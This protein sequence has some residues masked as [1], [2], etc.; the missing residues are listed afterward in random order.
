MSQ[1]STSRSVVVELL[2][3]GM[4]DNHTLSPDERYLAL[5]GANPKN[6]FVVSLTQQ[7]FTEYVSQL[8]YVGTNP[9]ATR[10]ARE[11]LE[12]VVRGILS[13]IPGLQTE[14][15]DADWLHLRLVVTPRELGL[16]PFELALTPD[17]FPGAGDRPFL[18]NPQRLTTLTRE[19]RQAT[20]R[21]YQWPTVPRI[22]FV[23]ADPGR[24]VPHDQHLDS[25]MKAVRGWARPLGNTAEPVPDMSPLIKEVAHATL[26]DIRQEFK[27]ARYTHVHILA[28]GTDVA[29]ADGGRRFALALH[30]PGSRAETDAVDGA[31][32]ADALVSVEGGEARRPAVVV[33][34]A[35]DSG[36]EGT[37]IFPG[38]SLAHAL[39]SYSIPYVLAS[40]FPLTEEGSVA[41]VDDLYPRLFSGEDPR[42][43]LYHL[44][45]VLAQK[46]DA[47]DWASLV[48]YAR[49]P[50][51]FDDQLAEVR[52]ATVLDAMKTANA[53]ADHALAH[54]EKIENT[55]KDVGA[56]LDQAI[57]D[58]EKLLEHGSPAADNPARRAEHLGLLGSAYKRKAEQLYRLA[59]LHP[60][61]AEDFRKRSNQGLEAARG[62]YRK[63]HDSQL[64]HHWTG[65]QY[66]SLTAAAKGTLVDDSDRWVVI[67]FAAEQD[68]KNPAQ[69]GWAL[70][71]MAE[72]YLLQPLTSPG[73]FEV[74]QP[75]A[76]EEARRYLLDLDE[77]GSPFEKESTARQFERYMTWW[78]D[79]FPTNSTKR[80]QAAAVDLRKLLP[81]LEEAGS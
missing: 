5:C 38:A 35:C 72:L 40:Q 74:M 75:K 24:A 55:F 26:A 66:L 42:C 10:M 68:L 64:S 46:P 29:E 54:R 1:R 69:R 62:W 32:L 53:W 65:C 34:A 17:G 16:L 44:R 9:T 23:W 67:R 18:M 2:R 4:T 19:V 79:A 56:Q 3:T 28:H 15:N 7:R 60:G 59:T 36:N 52:L 77:T 33:V 81:P 61:A 31:R 49:F 27:K 47:H 14:A 50:E 45:E 48:A 63:G 78:P 13:K 37:P 25:L 8:R 41:L 57:S 30:Q 6:D 58:L 80:L 43:A 70:G 76:M 20:S 22:L 11:E 73:Q 12:G 39:H 21:G 71:T 51:D